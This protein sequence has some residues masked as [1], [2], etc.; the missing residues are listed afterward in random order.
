MGS[1]SCR[2]YLSGGRTLLGREIASLLN[3][4]R[5][6]AASC[7]RRT[8]QGSIGQGAPQLPCHA[9]VDR[10]KVH[11]QVRLILDP[12]SGVETRSALEARSIQLPRI[13]PPSPAPGNARSVSSTACHLNPRTD[14]RSASRALRPSNPEATHAPR[15]PVRNPSLTPASTICHLNPRATPGAERQPRHSEVRARSSDR[16]RPSPPARGSWRCV[17]P[18]PRAYERTTPSRGRIGPST[19]HGLAA[20]LDGRLAA[21]SRYTAPA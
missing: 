2:A 5:S 7:H 16:G 4:R 14:R 19:P 13:L 12:L 3:P 1:R 20:P 18:L 9:L 21:R 10:S 8:R 15:S 6:T 17:P 11:A